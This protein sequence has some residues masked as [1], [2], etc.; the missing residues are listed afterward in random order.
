MVRKGRCF[1]ASR[2]VE[3]N[4]C[5]ELRVESSIGA[6]DIDKSSAGSLKLGP[7]KSCRAAFRCK[8][9]PPHLG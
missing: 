8:A 4:V 5:E 9:Q 1:E 2:T 7:P 6:I 3:R